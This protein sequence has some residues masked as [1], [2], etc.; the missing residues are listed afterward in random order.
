MDQEKLNSIFVVKDKNGNRETIAAL[1]L[2]SAEDIVK[3]MVKHK[4][5]TIIDVVFG[6]LTGVSKIETSTNIY[7]IHV[8]RLHI[9][10][11]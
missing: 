5:E 7:E 10:I 3:R 1:N 4:G 6:E 8:Q 9:A 2:E 11:V